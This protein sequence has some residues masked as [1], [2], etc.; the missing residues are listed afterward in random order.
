MIETKLFELRDV[1][2]FI[3]IIAMLMESGDEREAW[4][5]RRAGYSRLSNLVLLT[6]LDGGAAHYDPYD[7]SG[8]TYPAAHEYITANWTHL[9]SGE[10]IDVRVALGETK[11]PCET[12]QA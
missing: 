4:L 9:E 12:E 1:G 7:W 3:P 11:E 5:L 8:R 6:R 2:T 10:L